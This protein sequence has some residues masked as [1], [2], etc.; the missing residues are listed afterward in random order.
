MAVVTI[1][2]NSINNAE[3]QPQVRNLSTVTKGSTTES[4]AALAVG[5]SDNTAS[6]YRAFRVKSSWRLSSLQFMNA[7]LT[8]GSSYKLGVALPTASGGGLPIA[9]ADVIFGSGVSFVSARPGYIDLLAPTVAGG[10]ADPANVEKRIW[11]LLGLTADPFVE[12]DLT[13]TAVTPA[14][15]GGN[16]GVKAQWCD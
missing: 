7:A 11:E 8:G 14:T 5:S 13:I 4:V 9:N 16:I 6:T 3:S 10:S 15:V 2:S 12:Y 1:K